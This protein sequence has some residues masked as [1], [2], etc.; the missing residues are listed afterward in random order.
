MTRNGDDDLLTT[1][2]PDE[3]SGEPNPHLRHYLLALY[4]RRWTTLAAFTVVFGA[5]VAYTFTATPVYRATA[6]VLIDADR[7]HVVDFRE[8]VEADEARTDYYQTQYNLLESRSLARKTL[9][10]LNIWNH[11]EFAGTPKGAD[12]FGLRALA[13]RLTNVWPAPR[14][15]TPPAD[16]ETQA[17]SRVID[18]FLQQLTVSPLR[19]SRLTDV[20][21]RSTDPSLAARIVNAHTRAFIEQ[22]LEYRFVASKQASDW[23]TGQLQEQRKHVESAEVALQRYRESQDAISFEDRENI[24]VQK[25]AD[26]NAAVTR[27]KTERIEKEARYNQLLTLQRRNA[28]LDTFPAILSN[29]FIQQQKAELAGLRRQE[30][31]L[32]DR[33]GDRHPEMV[34]LRIAIDEAEDKLDTEIAKVVESVRNEFVAAQAAERSLIEALNAQKQEAQSMNRKAIEYGVLQRD[35]ETNRQIYDSLLQRAK[36]TGVSTEL[37][38]SNIRIVDAAE[39]PRSP[40]SPRRLVNVLAGL[41]GAAAF[42]IFLAFFFEYIDNRLKTPEDVH[43]HL[44]LSALA[45]LPRVPWS[46]DQPLTATAAD[47]FSEAIRGL[48]TNLLFSTPHEQGARTLLVTSTGPQEGKS[49]TVASLAISLAEAGHRVLLVDADLRRPR[50]HHIMDVP[51]EPGLSNIL[52]GSAAAADVMRRSAIETLSLIPSGRIP[53]NPAELLGSAQFRRLLESLRES[54]EW[55]LLD[56]PPALPVTDP[57]IMAQAASG[58]IFIVDAEKT[59]R[60]RARYALMKLRRVRTPLLGA[61][62]NGVDLNRNSAYYA[63][64]YSADDCQYYAART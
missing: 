37:K 49:V 50:M 17:E 20:S 56:S 7:Q 2:G 47:G 39:V 54:F 41:I 9:T 38:T 29:Q 61:V 35:V 55:I 19:A 45:I 26:L 13:G 15:V 18:R 21:F 34:K 24:V 1:V 23:L 59:N 58:V 31:Q 8:V 46:G 4:K 6:R 62:L 14:R 11:P 30:L 44:G 16:D 12:R 57:A 43:H 48:R 27:A 33:F 25:L 3:A 36:E 22:N 32:S 51:Q 40:V 60:Y 63:D 52:V 42:G 10:N 53:P 28:P 64:Y 5:V